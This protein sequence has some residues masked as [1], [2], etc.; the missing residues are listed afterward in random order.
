MECFTELNNNS[1]CRAVVLSGA[2]K[3]FSA[4]NAHM[5]SMAG[6]LYSTMV[7]LHTTLLKG[8]VAVKC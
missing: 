3:N 6:P 8:L 4:G 2:G 7:Q 1:D 5:I